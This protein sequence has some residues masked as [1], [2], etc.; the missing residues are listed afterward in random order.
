MLTYIDFCLKIK[1]IMTDEQ[2]QSQQLTQ[3]LD[4]TFDELEKQAPELGPVWACKLNFFREESQN[5]NKIRIKLQNQIKQLQ[6]EIDNQKSINYELGKVLQ[7]LQTENFTLKDSGRMP[8]PEQILSRTERPKQKLNYSI[9]I[10]LLRATKQLQEVEQYPHLTILIKNLRSPITDQKP[11]EDLRELFRDCVKQLFRD[12]QLKGIQRN[13]DFDK[14]K[15]QEPKLTED[16][17]SLKLSI[18]DLRTLQEK[19]FYHPH[20]IRMVEAQIFQL[21]CC[22]NQ[23]CLYNFK[24]IEQNVHPE[25]EV[26]LYF[27]KQSQQRERPSFKEQLKPN[28]SFSLGKS[29]GIEIIL[30]DKT[31]QKRQVFAEIIQLEREICTTPISQRKK[32]TQL[33][34]QLKSAKQQLQVKRKDI[35]F[36]QI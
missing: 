32:L 31:L 6:I 18:L 36:L 27:R 34:S 16:D 14:Y 9:Q 33:Q 1:K 3:L 5:L 35:A 23:N 20:F 15:L 25:S 22:S 7:N 12:L 29:D 21:K 19:F 11:P 4:T 2:I 24:K 13:K 28:Y 30:L 26:S 10:I 8:T 17:K